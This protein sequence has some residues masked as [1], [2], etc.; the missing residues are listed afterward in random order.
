MIGGK[1]LDSYSPRTQQE[2][3]MEATAF[4]HTISRIH[5]TNK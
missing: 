5:E 3:Y 1:S 2:L 4:G